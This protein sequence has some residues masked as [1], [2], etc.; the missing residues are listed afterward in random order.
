MDRTVLAQITESYRPH[1]T[2]SDGEE[3][4]SVWREFLPV[5]FVG[6][7]EEPTNMTNTKTPLAMLP[8]CDTPILYYNL[9]YLKL[10]GFTECV[11]MFPERYGKV[12]EEFLKEKGE[13]TGLTIVC[14]SLPDDMTEVQALYSIKD[15]V[16]TT[17]YL[18]LKGNQI[19]VFPYYLISDMHRKYR[20][21]V[22]I[23]LSKGITL[24][25]YLVERKSDPNKMKYVCGYKLQHEANTLENPPLPKVVKKKPVYPQYNPIR[26]INSGF[27]IGLGDA[28]SVHYLNALETSN[29]SATGV[30]LNIPRRIIY[31]VGHL[32]FNVFELSPVLVVS[33]KIIELISLLKED[34][35]DSKLSSI[36]EDLIPWIVFQSHVSKEERP[37]AIQDFSTNF[38]CKSS[39]GCLSTIPMTMIASRAESEDD[40]EN[41]AN[42]FSLN[43]AE[44]YLFND[45]IAPAPII[46]SN[47]LSV[48]AYVIPDN[49]HS[50]LP[51]PSATEERGGKKEKQNEKKQQKQ[52]QQRE[53]ERKAPPHI[54]PLLH[55]NVSSEYTLQI[56]N[57]NI[58]AGLLQN[59]NIISSD[60]LS[61]KSKTL[62]GSFIGDDVTLQGDKNIVKNSVIGGHSKVEDSKIEGSIIMGYCQIMKGCEI[63]DCVVAPNILIEENTKMTGCTIGPGIGTVSSSGS[64]YN[65]CTLTTEVMSDYDY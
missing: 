50:R 48:K 39:P 61:V 51:L 16:R 11:L 46:L 40:N 23:V 33:A 27:T 30:E 9:R 64:P 58:L 36:W 63:K 3:D 13:A 38:S 47:Q 21:L 56:A 20:P 53:R 24:E 55:I 37:R 18:L 43:E 19:F 29:N 54:I 5:I 31:D 35:I 14:E 22:S 17:N 6:V 28:A 62:S 41:P 15:K 32:S 57:K 59:L 12:I 42:E 26:P 52:Q 10:S 1:P 25:K 65:N 2:A 34:G 8:I 60:F 4:E 49:V 7:G 45:K 44:K